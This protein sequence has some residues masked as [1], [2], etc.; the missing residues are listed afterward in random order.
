MTAS[1]ASL[2]VPLH[3][4]PMHAKS[5]TLFIAAGLLAALLQGCGN[6]AAPE[7]EQETAEGT[8]TG[9]SATLQRIAEANE[10]SCTVQHALENTTINHHK[11]TLSEYQEEEG[12]VLKHHVDYEKL[13]ESFSEEGE[14]LEV[15]GEE[16]SW[17]EAASH[18][19]SPDQEDWVYLDCQGGNSHIV[20]ILESDHTQV[21][22]GKAPVFHEP[23]T[24]CSGEVG[25]TIEDGFP[26][27]TSL[28]QRGEVNSTNLESGSNLLGANETRKVVTTA[29]GQQLATARTAP[30][31]LTQNKE[32]RNSTKHGAN[33]T[34]KA[35]T[36][37]Q[38]E[39]IV[40]NTTLKSSVPVYR[41]PRA[42]RVVD[43]ATFHD[44]VKLAPEVSAHA[45]H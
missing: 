37:E 25:F 6:G 45:L 2:A 42:K 32:E 27:P 40:A 9:N 33:D 41:S 31:S 23:I 43:D 35:V 5:L 3:A 17:E 10:R 14:D 34:L 30:I 7:P 1:Q 26:E 16:L 24:A 13:A 36:T 21:Y 4:A 15:E 28:M 39:M 38:G 18:E 11:P 44:M 12:C 29:Q 8:P 19:L 22:R 20:M